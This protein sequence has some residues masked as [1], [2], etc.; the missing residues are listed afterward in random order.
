MS[1]KILK[2]KTDLNVEVLDVKYNAL[3]NM[4]SVNDTGGIVSP[5]FP[6]EITKKNFRCLGY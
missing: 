1:L 5:S 3:G 6:K 2:K 4:M